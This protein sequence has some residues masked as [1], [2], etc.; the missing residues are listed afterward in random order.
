MCENVEPA[1][2]RHADHDFVGAPLGAELDGF[3]EHR[4]HHVETLDRELL[5]SEE[6]APE[7]ALEPLDLGQ[8]LEQAAPLAALNG[9]R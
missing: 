3:V 7:V 2:V 1:A 9:F 4:D 5:L 8:P 6:R